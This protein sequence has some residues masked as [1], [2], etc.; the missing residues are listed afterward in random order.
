MA[1]HKETTWGWMLAV[2][3]FFAGMGGAMVAIAG[4]VQ[5]FF[6]EMH[7]SVVGN[8]IGPVCV[9]IGAGFLIF[10]LGRPF[11][12]WR[13]F[14]NPKAI[15][16]FGAWNMLMAIGSGVLLASFGIESLPWVGWTW[17]ETTLSVLCIVFGLIVATYPG[18]LL[19]SHK[20]RPFWTG[21]GMASLFLLSS[22]VTGLAAHSLASALFDDGASW[23]KWIII[24]LLGLQ[25]VLWGLYLYVKCT[26]TTD[27]EAKAAAMWVNGKYSA[28]FWGIFMV[29]GSLIPLMLFALGSDTLSVVGGILVLLGGIWMRLTV[30]DS[31]NMRTWLPGEEFFLSRLPKGD[32]EFLK[33]LK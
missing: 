21:P 28:G 3:F 24:A 25:I 15:L 9:A 8:L 31:G 2:D 12:A 5:L 22:L 16:T 29:L 10:E 19:G 14:M 7:T 23:W 17:A 6:K 33:A 32:E 26:G 11:Q 4:I 18:V 13:V 27:R 1:D 20:G 30:V